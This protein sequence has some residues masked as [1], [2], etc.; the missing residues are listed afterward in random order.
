MLLFQHPCAWSNG[1]KREKCNPRSFL[2]RFNVATSQLHRVQLVNFLGLDT[3][4][5]QGLSF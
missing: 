4:V 3:E 5:L 2:A 1:I